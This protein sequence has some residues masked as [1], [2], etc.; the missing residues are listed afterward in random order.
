MDVD[1]RLDDYIEQIGLAEISAI[2]LKDHKGFM[3][4]SSGVWI[5]LAIRFSEL[6]Q[7]ECRSS[8]SHI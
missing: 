8:V 6:N 5:Y 3:S 2:P 4:I 1:S 7:F